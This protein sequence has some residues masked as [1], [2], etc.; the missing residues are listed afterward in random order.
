VNGI[1]VLA[2][3]ACGIANTGPG[4]S[5]RIG[6][7]TAAGVH[8]SFTFPWADGPSTVYVVRGGSSRPWVVREYPGG[9]DVHYWWLP[10]GVQSE[11]ISALVPEPLHTTSQDAVCASAEGDIS[12]IRHVWG[13]SPGEWHYA[14]HRYEVV[15]YVLSAGGRYAIGSRRRT[16]QRY[17]DWKA[18]LSEL[19]ITCDDLADELVRK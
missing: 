12:V 2:V 17:A 7:R 11:R 9:S 3:V 13:S 5:V 18:A 19:K 15:T 8:A 1:A 10:L 6:C 4:D 16:S 14:P